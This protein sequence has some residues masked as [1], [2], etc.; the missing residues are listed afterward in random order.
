VPRPAEPTA[1]RA[2][3][4]PAS[5]RELKGGTTPNVV[6]LGDLSLG[7]WPLLS[8]LGAAQAYFDTPAKIVKTGKKHNFEVLYIVW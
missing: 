1:P 2:R 7:N 6:Q 4:P 8:W 3:E 5:G